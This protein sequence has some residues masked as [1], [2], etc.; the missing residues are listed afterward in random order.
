[1]WYWPIRER[2]DILAV[3]APTF[4]HITAQAGIVIA[5]IIGPATGITTHLRGDVVIADFEIVCGGLS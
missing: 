3:M 4:N 1:M 5:L 2:A